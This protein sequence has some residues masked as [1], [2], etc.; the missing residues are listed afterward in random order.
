MEID[1]AKTVLNSWIWDFHDPDGQIW[2]K[3]K[4]LSD[5]INCLARDGVANAPSVALAM[6]ASRQLVGHGYLSWQ[7]Y[8]TDHFSVDDY[9]VIAPER[10]A[11]LING[12]KSKKMLQLDCLEFSTIAEGEWNWRENRFAIAS[13]YEGAPWDEGYF[14][15]HFS[16]WEIVVNL[17]QHNTVASEQSAVSD[18][19][20]LI[21]PKNSGGRKPTYD[22]EK[23]VAALVFKWADSGAWQ[24]LKQADVVEAMAEW[25]AEQGVTP[26]HSLLKERAQWL[27][28]EFER[29]NPDG[30]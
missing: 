3:P 18:T 25:F 17:P 29:R 8:E 16:A 9:G 19:R 6:L 2:P 1:K 5:V 15:E 20:Q 13:V 10:W 26:S 24:P 7:K 28:R 22:W 11:T 21:P 23:A 12:L 4:D 30:Q 14:E 27:F